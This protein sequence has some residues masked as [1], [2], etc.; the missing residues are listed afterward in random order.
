MSVQN[1]LKNYHP[2]LKNPPQGEENA[3]ITQ[4]SKTTSGQ[5]IFIDYLQYFLLYKKGI[6]GNEMYIHMFISKA[7]DHNYF[8]TLNFFPG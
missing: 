7:C 4:K 2:Q 5:Q 8:F 3:R 1:T 6:S